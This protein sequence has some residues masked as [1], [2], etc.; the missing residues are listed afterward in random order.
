[1]SCDSTHNTAVST[2]SHT[3]PQL[4]HA[5]V[6]S[7]TQRSTHQEVVLGFALHDVAPASSGFLHRCLLLLQER[8]HGDGEHAVWRDHQWRIRCKQHLCWTYQKHKLWHV[9][10]STQCK[11]TNHSFRTLSSDV[12]VIMGPSLEADGERSST[13]T[14]ST[15]SAMATF[16]ASCG[17]VSYCS[18]AATDDSTVPCSQ[19]EYRSASIFTETGAPAALETCTGS[20]VETSKTQFR[21]QHW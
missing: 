14:S 2:A 17:R 1:M 13:G 11:T 12:G 16:K 8:P 9:L 6:W 21:R 18:A 4:C 20:F 19:S 5:I 15:V 10:H 3:K 7:M